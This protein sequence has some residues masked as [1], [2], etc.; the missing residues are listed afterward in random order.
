MGG[1]MSETY[2][3]MQ[4][5]VLTMTDK[6]IMATRCPECNCYYG[7]HRVSCSRMTV[8]YMRV[9]LKASH[10]REQRNTAARRRLK[11]T[12]AL[13]QG[14]FHLL[15]HENNKLRRCLCR[16]ALAATNEMGNEELAMLIEGL[17]DVMAGRV[18]ELKRLRLESEGK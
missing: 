1:E 4:N 18:R 17:K 14:K 13:W 16:Q 8:D 12:A 9:L 11:E 15:R 2:E 7:A 10:N 5:R 3:E 6:E